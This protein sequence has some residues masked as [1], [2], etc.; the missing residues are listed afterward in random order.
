VK[1]RAGYKYQ[2]HEDAVFQTAITGNAVTDKFFVLGGDGTLLIRAGYAWDGCTFVWDDKTNARAGLVHDV[3]YQMLREG[4]LVPAWREAVDKQFGEMCRA[5]GMW[6][7][8]AW[9]YHKGVSW[10]GKSA[11]AKQAEKIYEAP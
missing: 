1:Y 2:L 5:D 11:A 3:F 9:Y 6:R 8:R 10:F 4:I 7:A